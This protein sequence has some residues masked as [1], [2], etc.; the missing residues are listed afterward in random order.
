VRVA[1]N[2]FSDIRTPRSYA[3][4]DGSR[5]LQSNVRPSDTPKFNFTE[6]WEI[7]EGETMEKPFDV[8][9]EVVVGLLRALEKVCASLQ[10]QDFYLTRATARC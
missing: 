2:G 1:F 4:P 8:R 3:A 5:L 6:W 9:E 7:G 10:L